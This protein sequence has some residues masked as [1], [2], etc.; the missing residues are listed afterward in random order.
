VSDLR[1]AGAAV[2]LEM[3][4]G[5]IPVEAN[6]DRWTLAAKLRRSRE[7]AQSRAELASILGLEATDIDANALWVNAGKE[8]LV[9]PL[10][11]DDAV[12]RARPRADAFAALKSEDGQSMAFVFHDRG[13]AARSVLA[14][15]F[16]PSGPAILEDPATGSACSNLGG[17][18]QL[19]RPGEAVERVVSQGEMVR[20]PSTLY[21]AVDAGGAI[22]VG[23]RVIELGRGR[24]E[25]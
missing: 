24:I 13:D 22:R 1:G 25:I 21:L 7:V 6:G 10:T 4:A 19:T 11:S 16:F 20:R 18:Y 8:Q 9:V 3:I 12:K 17:W 23:G 15:F 5:I 14:R 2:K